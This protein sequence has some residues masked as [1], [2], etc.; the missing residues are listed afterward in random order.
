MS[1]ISEQEYIDIGPDRAASYCLWCWGHDYGNC[2]FC[3][4]EKHRAERDK[5]K[6][7][8]DA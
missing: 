5:A 4:V 7:A 3:A 2:S 8:P 6:E 1:I